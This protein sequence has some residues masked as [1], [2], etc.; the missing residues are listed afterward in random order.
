MYVPRKVRTIVPRIWFTKAS[1]RYQTKRK[2][3]TNKQLNKQETN[4]DDKL[5][6]SK[7]WCTP[8]AISLSLF[9]FFFFYCQTTMGIY[10]ECLVLVR[11]MIWHMKVKSKQLVLHN[12]W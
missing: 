3:K 1:G 8:C 10:T 5:Q 7:V 11:V 12:L 4:S 2:Q 6:Y 9:H